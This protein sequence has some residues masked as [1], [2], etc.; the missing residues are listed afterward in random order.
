MRKNDW[1]EKPKKRGAYIR[2]MLDCILVIS[3]LINVA[4]WQGKLY[5]A[6]EAQVTEYQPR[7]VEEAIAMAEDQRN[8]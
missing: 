7:T 4:V 8:K 3:V 2:G 5:R 6:P 1:D